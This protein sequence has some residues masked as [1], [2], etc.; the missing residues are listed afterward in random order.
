MATI[1]SPTLHPGQVRASVEEVKAR[2]GAPPWAER[3]AV[4][5]RFLIT[6]ICQEPGHQ[7]DW[8]YHLTDEAWYI[9]EGRLSWTLEGYPEPVQVSAGDW[10]MAPANTYHFIQVHGDQPAIRIAVIPAG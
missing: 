7:N 10:I 4:N 5:D 8:H 6:V 3:I 2:R 9:Y 1:D